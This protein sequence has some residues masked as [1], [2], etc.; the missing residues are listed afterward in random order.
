[1]GGR[2]AGVVASS[3]DGGPRLRTPDV[4]MIFDEMFT[5]ATRI[6]E[7]SFPLQRRFATEP[8]LQTLVRVPTGLGKT[9]MAVLGW[10]WRRRFGRCGVPVWITGLPRR[11]RLGWRARGRARRAPADSRCAAGWPRK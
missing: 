11:T 8:A 9:A 1:M 3:R 5:K 6:G 2:A 7:G 10:L 4:A